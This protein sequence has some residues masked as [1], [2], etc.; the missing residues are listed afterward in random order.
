M[1]YFC[2]VSLVFC[3][4]PSPRNTKEGHQGT[5]GCTGSAVVHILQTENPNPSRSCKKL[6]SRLVCVFHIRAILGQL[7]LILLV[8]T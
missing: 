8:L 4:T 5:P 7:I 3:E 1:N 6:Q 2:G